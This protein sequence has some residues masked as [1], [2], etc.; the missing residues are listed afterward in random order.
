M[1]PKKLTTEVKQVI[2]KENDKNIFLSLRK[3]S[4]EFEHKTGITIS[5]Q[6]SF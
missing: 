3:L 4:V 6:K 5:Y 1:R 2:D